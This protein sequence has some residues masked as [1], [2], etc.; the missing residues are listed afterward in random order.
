MSTENYPQILAIATK[1]VNILQEKGKHYGRS[2]ILRGGVGAFMMLARK[3]DRIE[4]MSKAS[5]YD[6]LNAIANG[7]DLID[8]IRDL[9]AYL[10]LV[11]SEHMDRL[12]LSK[13][14]VEYIKDSN[15]PLPDGH[16]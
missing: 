8:D 15:I 5:G 14:E 7:G 9:R 12:R 2:W 13:Q 3:W 11:E 16:D 10:L 4:N 1:D 6:I